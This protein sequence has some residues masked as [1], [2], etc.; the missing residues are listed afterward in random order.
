MRE[1]SAPKSRAQPSL[2]EQ[3]LIRRAK[4]KELQDAGYGVDRTLTLAGSREKVTLRTST[5]N[6][7]AFTVMPTGVCRFTGLLSYYDQWQIQL[8]S[9]ADIHIPE[10]GEPAAPATH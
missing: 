7:V 8:R 5:Q 2:S 9:T 3:R 10:S 1:A 4:L 6:D